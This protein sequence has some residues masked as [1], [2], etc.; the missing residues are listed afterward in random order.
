LGPLLH[1]SVASHP[2]WGQ[3]PMVWHRVR[4]SIV[5]A[6][7]KEVTDE[8]SNPRRILLNPRCRATHLGLGVCPSPKSDATGRGGLPSASPRSPR[9]KPGPGPGLVDRAAGWFAAGRRPGALQGGVSLTVLQAR[10]L[11][12]L[13]VRGSN[14]HV[15]R[16]LIL[17]GH[18]RGFPNRQAKIEL[19]GWPRK[20][21]SRSSQSC[22]A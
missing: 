12:H 13:K 1:H 22:T 4:H 5:Y 17:S 7:F 6:V 14:L 15:L 8:H 11:P 18:Q 9:V 21:W 3:D 16:R 20:C 2:V 19:R 10:S